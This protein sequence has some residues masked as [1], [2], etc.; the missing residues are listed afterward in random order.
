MQVN[1]LIVDSPLLMASYLTHLAQV[2]CS[3][4]THC[5]LPAGSDAF[6]MPLFQKNDD[7]GLVY[8]GSKLVPHFDNYSHWRE[9]RIISRFDAN[10]PPSASGANVNCPSVHPRPH[11]WDP[12]VMVQGGGS[13]ETGKESK[14]KNENNTE[15]EFLGF[16]GETATRSS[17]VVRLKGQID[18]MLTPLLL[19][20]LQ[21]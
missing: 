11:P 4:W 8:I 12:F 10:A 2:R 17:L 7:G 9:V 1:R 3:N 6:S 14:D 21:R 20:G 13:D 18:V 15:L 16:Q 19:E 5:S